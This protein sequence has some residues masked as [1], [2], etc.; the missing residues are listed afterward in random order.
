[1][2]KVSVFIERAN[3]TKE[4]E[5]NDLTDLLKQVQI[6]PDTVLISINDK[7]VTSKAIVK[8]NDQIKLLSVISGG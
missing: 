4:L 5:V 1:M 2:P 3:V 7:L 8:E 6:N